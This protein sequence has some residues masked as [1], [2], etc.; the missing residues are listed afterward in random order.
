MGESVAT[1]CSAAARLIIADAARVMRES[2]AAWLILR[3]LIAFATRRLHIFSMPARPHSRHHALSASAILD[4]CKTAQGTSGA[5]PP[6]DDARSAELC[7]CQLW[8]R[9]DWLPRYYRHATPRRRRA[10][11]A[12]MMS[13]PR[14]R[15]K[16][17]RGAVIEEGRSIRVIVD[18][19]AIIEP[20]AI[21][22]QLTAFILADVLPGY[23]RLWEMS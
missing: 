13:S 20:P 6:R 12:D 16:T 4:G 21:P 1:R 10:E 11:S 22:V 17:L 5:G 3:E 18:A 2:D 14:L 7:R 23:F 8:R 15:R 9:A 19:D